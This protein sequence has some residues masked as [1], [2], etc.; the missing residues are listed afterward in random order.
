MPK[1]TR[2]R[3]LIGYTVW[4]ELARQWDGQPGPNGKFDVNKDKVTRLDVAALV[5]AILECEGDQSEDL[6]REIERKDAEG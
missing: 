5:D 4:A 1:D 6:R 2:F 3:A